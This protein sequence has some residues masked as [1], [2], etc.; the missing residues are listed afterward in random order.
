MRTTITLNPEARS[1]IEA[2]VAASGLT[3]KQV[4]NSA[5]VRGLTATGQREFHTKVR[6]MGT[7]AADLDRALQLA[8]QLEDQSVL[9]KLELGK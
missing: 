2:E 1:L 9:A 7:P 8:G 6:S 4:V 3:F 5:I